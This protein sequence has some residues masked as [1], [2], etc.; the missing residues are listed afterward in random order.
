MFHASRGAYAGAMPLAPIGKSG[1]LMPT[2]RQ[3]GQCL[4]K[5]A[6]P[7][8]IGAAE[9]AVLAS[10]DNPPTSLFL[11]GKK[12]YSIDFTRRQII[13]AGC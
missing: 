10:I 6:K 13:R 7:M 9:A 12:V 3:E 1:K 2:N 8:P 11:A 5:E 4:S